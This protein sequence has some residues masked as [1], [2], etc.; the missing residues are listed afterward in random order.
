MAGIDIVISIF[1]ALDQIRD[2]IVQQEDF[3]A[4]DVIGSV[5]EILE[6]EGIDLQDIDDEVIELLIRDYGDPMITLALDEFIDEENE[7]DNLATIAA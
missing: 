3:E 7:E 2:E 1:Y 4:F 6:D 5:R